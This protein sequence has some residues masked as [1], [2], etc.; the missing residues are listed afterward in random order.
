[1]IEL[2][3]I[4]IFVSVI[5]PIVVGLVELVKRTVNVPKNIV[6]AISVG[7]GLLVGLLGMPF[8][9]LDLVYRLWAGLFAG[10]NGVGVFEFTK[11][12]YGYTKEK[13]GDK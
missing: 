1:M 11:K 2:A 3:E 4:L 12:R 8:T 13:K 7:V 6:P 10:G 9:D 5:T